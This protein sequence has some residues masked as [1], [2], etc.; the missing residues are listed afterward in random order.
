MKITYIVS[1]VLVLLIITGSFTV[2]MIMP[3]PNDYWNENITFRITAGI[4]FLVPIVVYTI[5]K[6]R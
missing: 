3:D 6:E 4:I 2:D 5:I 1:G